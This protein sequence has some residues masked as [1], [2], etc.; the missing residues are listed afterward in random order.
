[1]QDVHELS[2]GQLVALVQRMATELAALRQENELLRAQLRGKGPGAGLPP[3][4]KPNRPA[5]PA[6]KKSRRKKRTESFVRRRETPTRWVEHRLEHCPECGGDLSRQA[7][8]RTRQVVDIAFVPVDITE[9]I[10]YRGYCPACGKW[11]LAKLRRDDGVIGQHRVGIHLMSLVATLNKA[12]RVTQ[13]GIQGLLKTLYGVHLSLGEITAILHTVAGWGKGEA[14]EILAQVRGSPV[15]HADETGWRQ[16]GR[17]G[18]VWVVCTDK[19]RYFRVAMSR[20]AAVIQ[21]MLGEDFAGS[22]VTDGYRG[23]DW[24]LGPRELCWTHILR[25]LHALKDE[26]QENAP[27]VGWVCAVTA[28]Y[29]EAKRIDWNAVKESERCSRA[30]RYEARLL[31]LVEPYLKDREAPQHAPSAHM[32]RHLKHLFTFVRR[33]EVPTD[34]NPAERAL[35]PVV[36]ARKVSG[37]TRSEQ[38]SETASVL[39]TLFGTWQLRG[40]NPLRAC[41]AMVS[42]AATIN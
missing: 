25:D 41:L 21:G 11:H 1:M 24:Y 39:Q 33:P 19:A 29:R 14:E 7:E 38:G 34:N 26:H 42:A 40:E 31:K 20:A 17:N 22:L 27:V 30:N 16:D 2:H 28:L 10:L 12:Y 23:Y 15:V 3:F 4:V 37:G 18:Y 8:H 9:H 32:H 5:K 6:G 13:R 36:I 35:R